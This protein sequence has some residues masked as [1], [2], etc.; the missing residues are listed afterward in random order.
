M[1]YVLEEA[2]SIFPDQNVICVVS[3]GTGAPGII[4]FENPDSTTDLIKVV[5]KIAN[6][7]E[8][9]SEDVA[10]EFSDKD[11]FYC[12]LNVEHGLQGVGFEEWERLADIKTHTDRHLQKYEVSRKIDRLVQVLNW[13]TGAL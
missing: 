1:K 5:K 7:C 9:V 2:R 8:A 11:G 12:R 4:G 3:I 13:R 6:D 10:R